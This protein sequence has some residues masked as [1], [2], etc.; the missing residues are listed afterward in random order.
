[1]IRTLA[2]FEFRDN[3]RRV[4]HHWVVDMDFFIGRYNLSESA[5][6]SI[7]DRLE[8]YWA[9]GRPKSAWDAIGPS[10]VIF[11]IRREDRSSWERFLRT[12][13]K[14]PDNAIDCCPEVRRI[15]RGMSA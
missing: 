11:R 5:T 6:K 9:K 13:L 1:M 3:S 4:G 10:S 14:D 2:R 7:R 12:L 8:A 15:P